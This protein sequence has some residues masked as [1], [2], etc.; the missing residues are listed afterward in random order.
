MNRGLQRELVDDPERGAL[1]E[2]GG[3]IRKMRYAAQGRGKSGG[4][5]VIYY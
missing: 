3:G 5:R 2:D 4:L 1:I